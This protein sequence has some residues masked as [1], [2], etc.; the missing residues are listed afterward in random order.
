MKRT[1]VKSKFIQWGFTS[2]IAMSCLFPNVAFAQTRYGMRLLFYPQVQEALGLSRQ[3]LRQLNR[4]V[5]EIE[6]KVASEDA[7]WQQ[8]VGSRC[9]IDPSAY[10]RC[11][12]ARE[13]ML[14]VTRQ[15][16]EKRATSTI[17]TSTQQSQLMQIERRLLQQR[18]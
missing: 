7:R 16:L 3:Q 12:A 13:N 2:A 6:S 8:G 18:R 17:L 1:H 10:E 9:M 14:Q 11:V 4:T 5:Q 15:M